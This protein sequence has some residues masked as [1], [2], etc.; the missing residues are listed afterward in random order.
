MLP[1][2]LIR[3]LYP[4]SSY[5]EWST[6]EL[7]RLT[8]IRVDL[9]TKF[10]FSKRGFG[11]SLTDSQIQLLYQ[12]IQ[13]N[14]P[15]PARDDQS[16]EVVVPAGG[17]SSVQFTEKILLDQ[18]PLSGLDFTQSSNKEDRYQFLIDALR[19]RLE[20]PNYRDL[21]RVAAPASSVNEQPAFRSGWRNQL[22]QVAVT[23]DDC[24]FDSI[25]RLLR[26][27]DVI[28]REYLLS[29]LLDRRAC[30]PLLLFWANSKESPL[31]SMLPA[32]SLTRT[33]IT[34]GQVACLATDF[35]CMRVAVVSLHPKTSSSRNTNS[36]LKDL[37]HVKS[38]DDGLALSVP[39]L[40]AGFGFLEMETARKNGNGVD[41]SVETVIVVHLVGCN[42]ELKSRI[43]PLV[44]I[45]IYSFPGRIPDE[46]IPDTSC[47]SPPCKFIC[48]EDAE[49]FSQSES[50]P[51]EGSSSNWNVFCGRWEAGKEFEK[52]MKV[53]VQ[54]I[55]QRRNKLTNA[56]E[57]LMALNDVLTSAMRKTPIALAPA[58]LFSTS[59]VVEI[60]TEGIRSLKDQLSMQKNFQAIVNQNRLAVLNYYIVAKRTEHQNQA[61]VLRQENEKIAL[62]EPSP[63]AYSQNPILN[64]FIRILSESD[65]SKRVTNYILFEQQM[66]EVSSQTRRDL[67]TAAGSDVQEYLLSPEH[68]WREMASLYSSVPTTIAKSPYEKYPGLAA[69]H[70]LDGFAIEMIDGDASCMNE[71]WFTAVLKV[72]EELIAGKTSLTAPKL[73]VL[74]ILG[75][76]KSGKS[77]LLNVMFGCR[78]RTNVERCTK[79]IYLQLIRST[80]AGFDY[81]L[82]LDVE[83]VRSMEIQQKEGDEKAMQ[84]DNRLAMLSVWCA[85]ATLILSNGLDLTQINNIVGV[86]NYLTQKS[87]S[88]VDGSY[89]ASRL[90]FIMRSVPQNYDKE[91]F[92]RIRE[93]LITDFK[94]EIQSSREAADGTTGMFLD[95]NE[96]KDIFLLGSLTQGDKPPNDN[97]RNRLW[98]GC[99]ESSGADF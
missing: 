97:S 9:K 7:A 24:L 87:G 28:S 14:L 89:R 11:N 16:R 85:D 35:S 70:L 20:L 74:S 15:E 33:R 57:S 59:G 80:R 36:I 99:Q 47:P 53:L 64:Q 38:L 31:S 26:F 82:V 77:T 32:L 83:G 71:I 12:C 61:V 17:I 42:D 69:I 18:E 46:F 86:V 88:Q 23:N 34:N 5:F 43:L 56:R 75:L 92:K 76:Q 98:C 68:L 37:F 44:D 84:H 25:A 40:E 67:G 13:G 22:Q 54:S 51:I 96:D 72:L 29:A 60:S 50:M 21:P 65:A 93:T 58:D 94:K 81:V 66:S 78:L 2:F 1:R 39:L 79:G 27:S 19:H 91:A 62:S 48:L 8:K 41:K 4:D 63:V 10:D 30:V 90:F 73:F 52:Q 95:F 49:V 45:A 6:A 55:A 3:N